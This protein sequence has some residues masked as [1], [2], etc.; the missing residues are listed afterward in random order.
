M[1][2]MIT[3]SV[4]EAIPHPYAFMSLFFISFIYRIFGYFCGLVHVFF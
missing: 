2:V 4:S 1:N 3:M